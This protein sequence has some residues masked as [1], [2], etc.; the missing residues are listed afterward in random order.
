MR[1]KGVF[2][3]LFES[4]FGVIVIHSSSERRPE[5]ERRSREAIIVLVEWTRGREPTTLG[6]VLI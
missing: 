5:V 3:E 6:S 1:K 2:L 4:G